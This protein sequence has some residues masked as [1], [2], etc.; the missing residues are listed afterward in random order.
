M[1]VK[2]MPDHQ[3]GQLRHFCFVDFIDEETAHKALGY[4]D[5]VSDHY[6]VDYV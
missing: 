4:N 6:W 2:L 3:T 1:S 5:H